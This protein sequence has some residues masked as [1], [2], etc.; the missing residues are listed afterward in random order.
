MKVRLAEVFVRR[1]LNEAKCPSCG[2]AGAYVGMGTVEC[3]ARGCRNFH[4]GMDPAVK[5]AAQKV[6]KFI[7]SNDSK[8]LARYVETPEFEEIAGVDDDDDGRDKDPEGWVGSPEKEP[9]ST[10]HTIWY[11]LGNDDIKT[12]KDECPDVVKKV[13]EWAK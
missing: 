9:G 5:A 2:N 4:G 1:T 6:V 7:D 12:L 10:F 8:G 11:T 3:P 13:R